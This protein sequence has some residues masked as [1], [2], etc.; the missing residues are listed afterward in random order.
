MNK[1]DKYE[2]DTIK[3]VIGGIVTGL[4]TGVLFSDAKTG[5]IIYFIVYY[6]LLNYLK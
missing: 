2:K 6:G 4:F 5:V 3:A 1:Y